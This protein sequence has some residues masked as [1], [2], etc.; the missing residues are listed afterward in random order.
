MNR[1]K[2]Y[3]ILSLVL[4]VAIISACQNFLDEPRPEATVTI[5]EIG[6]STAGL[7]AALTGAWA[8]WTAPQ[9]YVGNAVIYPEALG[10]YLENTYERG[11]RASDEAYRRD[12][13]I[14]TYGLIGEFGQRV[15]RA[16]NLA[17]QVVKAAR[18]DQPQ[19]EAWDTNRDRL[20]GEG[21]FLRSWIHF[22]YIKMNGDQW[23]TKNP[24]ANA[25]ALGPLI[26]FKPIL[27]LE[28]LA[29]ART[30]LAAAYDSTITSLLQ[31]DLPCWQKCIGSKMIL[32]IR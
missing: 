21:L 20:L 6:N 28:D 5:E 13:E 26:H 3:S 19:D 22:E 2:K 11:G 4:L 31:A 23:I 18:E 17:A 14:T 10:D 32:I 30:P 24:A 9:C 29:L 16:E 8:W 7:D 15:S 12:F 1:I 25:T 27:S